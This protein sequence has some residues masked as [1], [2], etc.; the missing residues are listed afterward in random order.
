MLAKLILTLENTSE[1]PISIHMSSIFQGMLMEFLEEDTCDWL[2]M[3]KR[4]PYSQFIRYD[5]NRIDW[6]I[7]T[8]T[9]KAYQRILIPIIKS[10]IEQ[11]FSTRHE[12]S[13]HIKNRELITISQQ[14]FLETNYFKSYTKT[15]TIEF[16]TPTSFK[17]NGQYKNYPTVRWIFQSLMN[18]YDEDSEHQLFDAEVLQLIEEQVTITQYKLKS[19]N[20]QLEGTKIPSFIGSVKLYVNSNQSIV[21]LINYLLKYGEFSGIGIKSAMGMGAIRIENRERKEL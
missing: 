15:F 1:K 4:H 13:F 12:I 18:K 6:T 20:F 9:K 10:S 8:F 19:T 3:Q 5:K 7:C 2:H 14:E 17:S 16:L 21:N 11:L